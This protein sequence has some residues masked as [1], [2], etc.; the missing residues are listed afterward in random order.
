MSLCTQAKY[1]GQCTQ[2]ERWSGTASTNAQLQASQCW[3]W[4]AARSLAFSSDIGV[5]SSCTMVCACYPAHQMF[6][7]ERIVLDWTDVFYHA[8]GC[9]V[10]SF[11]LFICRTRSTPF[12]LYR[13]RTIWAQYQQWRP[14]RPRRRRQRAQAADPARHGVQRCP[15]RRR[16]S[17]SR[18]ISGA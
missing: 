18:S 15:L 9:G 3:R 12:P 2:A 14:R 4:C 17:R 13:T 5:N 10:A 6:R 1:D 7:D 8:L 16:R 11:V